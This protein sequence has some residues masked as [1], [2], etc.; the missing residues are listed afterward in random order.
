VPG[1][2]AGAGVETLGALTATSRGTQVTP[3]GAS[4]GTFTTI[5]SSTRDYRYVLGR[6]IG[7]VDTT[8]N[9]SVQTLDIGTGSALIPGLEN[10]YG[11]FTSG[12]ICVPAPEDLGRWVQVPS[13]TALQ[14]R[15]QSHTT[16]T[17]AKS[18]CIYGVY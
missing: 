17:E 11:T 12:E 6:S 3:G 18:V 2:W 9:V 15:L 5:A 14:A 7:S 13:G 16:D 4:E 8:Q 1:G 10:F